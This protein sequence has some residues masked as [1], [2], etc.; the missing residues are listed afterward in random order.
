MTFLLTGFV[1]APLLGDPAVHA[2]TIYCLVVLA[3]VALTCMVADETPRDE[4]PPFR[5]SELVAAYSIDVVANSDFFW[6]FV[7]RVF[8]YMGISLQA[9][10]L[11]MMRDVQQVKPLHA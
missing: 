10:V 8:Y 3:T 9:F 6:V 5:L 11:F 4:A 1:P 2:Y 7:T